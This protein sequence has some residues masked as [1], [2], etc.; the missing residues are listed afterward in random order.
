MKKIFI[1]I[2]GLLLYSNLFAKQNVINITTDCA[3]VHN[4]IVIRTLQNTLYKELKKLSLEGC[5]IIQVIPTLA[6][7]CVI[8]YVIIYNEVEK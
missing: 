2:F 7:G 6:D 1:S 8:G 5:E 4:T 3:N